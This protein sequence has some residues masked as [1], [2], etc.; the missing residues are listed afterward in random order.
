MNI[1]DLRRD[2]RREELSESKV[3]R[4][5]IAQF[6]EWLK[7]ALAARLPEP[8][9]MTLATVGESGHP[10]ARIVLL[11]GV[12]ASGFTFFTNYESRKGREIERHPWASLVFYWAELEREVRIEGKV[13]KVD[14]AESSAYFDSRPLASRIG[15]WASPQS[16]VIESRQWLERQFAQA[17]ARFG[18]QVPRPLHWGGYRVVP[19]EIEFWQG[20]ESRLHDRIVYR[21]Q[22]DRGWRIERLAP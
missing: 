18:E 20:R 6:Q 19:E 16:R 14:G 17:R 15:A 12:D 4:D 9:A 11:K 1:A 10:S 7:E 8:T 22:P 2:Y 21:L 5:A 13:S 3:D